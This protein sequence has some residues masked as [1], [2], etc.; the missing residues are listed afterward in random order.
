MQSGLSPAHPANPPL[1]PKP[2]ELLKLIKVK[3]RID[4]ELEVDVYY[5]FFKRLEVGFV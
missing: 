4:V 3:L 2:K 1:S 5:S